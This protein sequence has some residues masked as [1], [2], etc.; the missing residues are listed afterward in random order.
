MP[1]QKRK[2]TALTDQTGHQEEGEGEGQGEGLHA[3]A[4]CHFL[5]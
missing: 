4:A 1:K 3:A 5:A 2:Y